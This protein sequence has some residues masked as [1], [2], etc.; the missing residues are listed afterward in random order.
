MNRPSTVRPKALHDSLVQRRR[1]ARPTLRSCGPVPPLGAV[2]GERQELGT[3]NSP[4]GIQITEQYGSPEQGFDV[5]EENSYQNYFGARDGS[6]NGTDP[7]FDGRDVSSI[8]PSRTL[9][10][11]GDRKSDQAGIDPQS[12]A[13][14]PVEQDFV[15]SIR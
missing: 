15:P 9:T 3:E 14:T 7:F 4:D 10:N 6:G 12:L 11:E 2:I 1:R 8:S 13:T 5:L